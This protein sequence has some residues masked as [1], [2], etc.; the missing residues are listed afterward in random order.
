[1]PLRP[2]RLRGSRAADPGRGVGVAQTPALLN[3]AQSRLGKENGLLAALRLEPQGFRA[4]ILREGGHLHPLG[5][6]RPL[7]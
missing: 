3:K 7:A 2:R 6:R 5:E 1:M 4:E